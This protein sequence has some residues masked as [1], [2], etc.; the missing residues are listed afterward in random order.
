VV[1]QEILVHPCIA[2]FPCYVLSC[3]FIFGI[4]CAF[5][6]EYPL[7]IGTFYLC[8]H[9]SIVT[10]RKELLMSHL[11]V[12]TVAEWSKAVFRNRCAVTR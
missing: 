3:F 7:T 8:S 12:V 5:I 1:Q 10:V 6:S 4:C 2:L 11:Q 9:F